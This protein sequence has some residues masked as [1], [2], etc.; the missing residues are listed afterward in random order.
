MAVLAIDFDRTI[1]ND[2]YEA[3]PEAKEAINNFREAGHKVVIHSCNNSKWIEKT[4]NNLDIRFDA[5]WSETDKGKL[6][7]D[8]YIDDRGYRFK[9]NWLEEG[10]E[11]LAHEHVKDKDN[12]KW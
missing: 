7:A 6:L 4:L 12:R 1:V 8:L 9:G 3:M 11:I 10:K 5:I 2:K